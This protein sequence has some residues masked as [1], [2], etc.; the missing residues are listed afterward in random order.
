LGQLFEGDKK[1]SQTALYWYKKAAEGGYAFAQA[2]LGQMYE[3]GDGL[4]RNIEQ[5]KSW[6]KK[7]IDNNNLDSYN[8]EKVKEALIRL[9]VT[10]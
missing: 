7:A 5:A 2:R 6:Y 4:P 9:S 8:K 3:H 10:P 1:D